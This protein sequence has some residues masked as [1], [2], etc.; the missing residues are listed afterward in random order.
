M[1]ASEMI[2]KV[3]RKHDNNIDLEDKLEWLD[4][5][6]SS[7]YEQIVTE[8][9][10]ETI[11]LVKDQAAYTLD[12][13]NFEDIEQL[14]VNNTEY[15]L[16]SA[17]IQQDKTYFKMDGSLNLYPVPNQDAVAGLVIMRRWKP[18]PLTED[19]YETQDLM[20]PKAFIDAYEFYLRS[21]I[22]FEQKDAALSNAFGAQYNSII[23]E[24]AQWYIQKQPN[25]AAY[26]TNQRW[27]K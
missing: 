13:F 15:S 14:K 7:I 27:N 5:V 16:G 26:K 25:I 17:L 8:L 12:T 24:Y 1:K 21:R 20:L 4:A 11:D 2:A 22:A 6:E 3:D 10:K 23:E 9:Y 19:T 18:D